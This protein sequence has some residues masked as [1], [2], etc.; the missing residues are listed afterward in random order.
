[1]RLSLLIREARSRDGLSPAMGLAG[2]PMKILDVNLKH[3]FQ[4]LYIAAGM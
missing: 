2:M 1:V 4:Y 3:Y